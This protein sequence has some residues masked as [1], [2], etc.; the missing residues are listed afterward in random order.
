MNIMCPQA[1]FSGPPSYR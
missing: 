1:N